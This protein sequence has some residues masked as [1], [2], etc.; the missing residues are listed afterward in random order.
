MSGHLLLAIWGTSHWNFFVKFGLKTAW[1]ISY[2]ILWLILK[3][4]NFWL[5]QGHSSTLGKILGLQK[6]NFF[7]MKER[8]GFDE[9]L[10]VLGGQVPGLYGGIIFGGM[11]HTWGSGRALKMK[12]SFFDTFATP[13][14]VLGIDWFDQESVHSCVLGYSTYPGLDFWIRHQ[15]AISWA[16]KCQFLRIFDISKSK[17]NSRAMDIWNFDP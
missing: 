2:D 5:L 15:L 12:V 7:S 13:K 16:F 10:G 6:I 8:Q 17:R 14:R 1:D 3:Y 11:W 9:A 4:V